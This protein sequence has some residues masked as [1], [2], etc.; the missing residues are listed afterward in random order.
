MVS[1][2]SLSVP[3]WFTL[4]RME[5][6]APLSTPSRSLATFVTKR[7]SPT[8]CAA[9]PAFSVNARHPSQSFSSIGSSIETIGYFPIQPRYISMSSS[10]ETSFPSTLYAP[11]RKNS[12]EAT[13]R[14]IDICSPGSYPARR[15]ASIMH[16][17]ARS[18]DPRSGANPPSSPTA[19]ERFSAVSMDFRP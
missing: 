1:M 12:L 17:R 9:A 16:S 14:A 8:I 3:I 15:T 5:L 2:V 11:S 4:I 7:S 19:V 13:S 10:A 6:A 18:F